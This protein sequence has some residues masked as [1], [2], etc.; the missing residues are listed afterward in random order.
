MIAYNSNVCK[1][2]PISLL[3]C[4]ERS[5]HSDS[6]IKLNIIERSKCTVRTVIQAQQERINAERIRRA[7]AKDKA[8][9]A[10]LGV[11]ITHKRVQ[12]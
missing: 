12:A 4:T 7:R 5:V 2:E 6:I 10:S 8:W 11:F 9:G 1:A 3:G